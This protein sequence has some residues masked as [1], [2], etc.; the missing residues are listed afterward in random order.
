M[1]YLTVKNLS[2]TYPNADQ[3]ALDQ[4]DLT[5]G[6]GEFVTLMGATGSGKSTLLRLLKPE[7]RQNGDMQGEVL[8]SLGKGTLSHRPSVS[9]D[10][11]L[12]KGSL[13]VVD[14]GEMDARTSARMIGYVAQS[15]EEQLV[16]DKVWH[17]LAF[18]L[19]NLGAKQGDIA[20]RVAEISSYFGIESRIERD[21]ATLSGGENQ[22]VNLAAVMT[23][24]PELLLLDEPTAQLD[25]IAATRF[26]E[27]VYRLNRETGVT[28]IMCEH[29]CEELFPLSDRIVILEK[30]RVAFDDTPRRVAERIGSD[31]GFAAFLPT[32]ARLYY[33]VTRSAQTKNTIPLSVR[34]GQRFV[35]TLSV[36]EKKDS[37][38]TMDDCRETALSLKNV[39]F[40]YERGGADILSDLELTV[41]SGEVFALLGANGAGKS[42]AA[43]VIAGLRKP[44]RGTVKLFDKPLKDYKNGSLYRGNLSLLPQDAESVFIHETVGEELKGC[45]AVLE[46]LPYDLRP[47]FDRHPYDISGG[48]RQLVAL[49]KALST[50]PR[51]LIMD[52]PSKGLDANVKSLLLDVIR[53]LKNEGV[54]VLLITHDVEFAALCADRCAL[55]ARGRIAAVDTTARFMSDNRFYTTAAS[56]ITRRFADGAY[57]AAL[58][59]ERFS[60]D[61]GAL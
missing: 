45:E 27:T 7:L 20:R 58:A 32:A 3:C 2:F 4:I 13:D 43:A 31:S 9:D 12:R 33:L 49:A 18:T 42:T 34:E 11:S 57:T 40:R 54:T 14:I 36:I 24:D 23:A 8:F 28:V 37:S 44:Y 51:F 52:E 17:E 39:F 50:E 22:L 16:T 46:K 29:R 61:G 25:P 15:P 5:I 47:L 55:F 1:A 30:G 59:A 60:L 35:E 26:I 41:K 19:E 10:S 6:R 53:R 21:T 48:E 56:R 38:D